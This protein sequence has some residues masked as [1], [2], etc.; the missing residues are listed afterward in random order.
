MVALPLAVATSAWCAGFDIVLETHVFGKSVR[1]SG[2]IALY[3]DRRK[4]GTD[5][6]NK[7][8]GK[9]HTRELAS[10][11]FLVHVG[12]EMRDKCEAKIQREATTSARG[13]FTSV[14]GL[15]HANVICGGQLRFEEAQ[16]GSHGLDD[17]MAA[18]VNRGTGT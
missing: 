10:E 4:V 2:I 16:K 18:I 17:G 15:V 1:T 12:S 11:G 7:W 5:Q 6:R 13:P 3:E 8:G 9:L 14:V